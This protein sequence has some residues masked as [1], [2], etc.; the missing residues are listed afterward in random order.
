MAYVTS[1]ERIGMEK[2]LKVGASDIVLRLL[3]QTN[4]TSVVF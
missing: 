4:L 1:F 2:G 3:R